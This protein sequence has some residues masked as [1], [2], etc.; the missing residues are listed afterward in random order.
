[1]L[2]TLSDDAVPLGRCRKSGQGQIIEVRLDRRSQGDRGDADVD[3]PVKTQ[4]SAGIERA[5][6]R[7]L[8]GAEVETHGRG[9]TPESDTGA[10]D[11]R[12]E[13]HVAGAGVLAKATCRSVEAGSNG[14]GEGGNGASDVVV[15]VVTPGGQRC[16]RGCR[17]ALVEVLEWRLRGTE[18][19]TVHSRDYAES[20]A[21][22]G[23]RNPSG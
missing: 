5:V 1:M 23:W 2:Q 21:I 4:S 19:I 18:S 22:V 9:D 13:E 14:S 6:G 16:Q 15:P 11:E 3:C 12:L 20:S 10:G 17:V 8:D 7:N